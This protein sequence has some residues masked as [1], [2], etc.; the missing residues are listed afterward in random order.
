MA[1][2]RN[3][4]AELVDEAT[5]CASCGTPVEAQA[6]PEQ[7]SY[8][9]Q[10]QNPYQTPYQATAPKSKMVAGLLGIFLGSLGIHN[11]YL[12]YTSRGLIQLLVSIFLSWTFVAPVAM[13]I[14][15]LI[16]GI[17]YLTG[18]ENYRTD[19]NG[20]YLAE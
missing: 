16:E 20:V 19:A 5:F 4:G 1:Y 14:W 15:G 17:F 9:A 2:C 6:A 3:C 18:K 8:Q 12:G 10:Y 11:F 13:G 7:N